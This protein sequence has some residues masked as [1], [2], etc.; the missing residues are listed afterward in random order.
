[1]HAGD[2][3]VKGVLGEPLLQMLL[4][5]ASHLHHMSN[6]DSLHGCPGTHVVVTQA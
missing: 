6:R 4:A 5:V 3:Q 2:L 1:M